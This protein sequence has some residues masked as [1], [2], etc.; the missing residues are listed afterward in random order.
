MK[1][2]L[3]LLWI[4][5]TILPAFSDTLEFKIE[6]GWLQMSDGV[7]LSV[8]YFKPA[9]EGEKYPVLL[10]LLPYRKDD[11]FYLRDYPLGAYFASHGYVVARVDVRGTGSSEGV[12]PTREYSDREIDDAV[13]LVEQLSK[14]PWSNG[15][16]GMY[17][18]S[19]SGFNAIH[20]AMRKPPALKAILAVDASDDLFHDD[21]HFLDGIYHMDRYEL[22]IDNDNGLPDSLEYRLDEEYFRNRFDRE[23][24]LFTYLRNQRDGEFWRKASVRFQEPLEVPTYLIGGLLDFYRDS[25]PRMLE[26]TKA[27]VIAEVGPWNHA[28]PDNGEPGPN[29]EWRRRALRWWDH[30]LKERDT[31]IL[32]EPAF[33]V[34]VR[35]SHLPDSQLKTTPGEWKYQTWPDLKAEKRRFFPRKDGSLGE[36]PEASHMEL[37]YRPGAGTAAGQWWG[38]PMPDMAA[39]D[40]QSLVFDSVPLTE[41]VEIVGFPHVNWRASVDAPLAHWVARL[42][43]VAPD[44]QV[45]LVTGAGL[46]GSQRHSLLEPRSLAP[47]ERHDYSFDLHF[48]T[49]RF[50]PGH[51]I[52][53][54]LSNAQ[55][56]MLWPTPHRMTCVTHLGENTSLT[57][58]V[59][60]LGERPE[61]TTL[62]PV[63]PR[64]ARPDAEDL[65]AEGWP[66]RL[67]TWYD[68]EQSM[69]YWT[70]EGQSRFRIGERQYTTDLST[71]YKVPDQ[72]PELAGFEGK[73]VHHIVL[74][75]DRVLDYST[76]MEVRS[77]A[78]FFYVRT[79]RE[80]AENGKQVRSKQWKESILRDFQ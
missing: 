37:P 73:G 53:L 38:E 9:I 74:E 47:G 41:T 50:P 29:Y 22:E 14:K 5:G 72:H 1:R 64:I 27:P 45:T 4:L 34:F 46:N 58:P 65:P 32:E 25:V 62:P 12:L 66:K 63:E 8:T 77:D 13:E 15:R 10:E 75:N 20:T 59:S 11:M 17:G 16:V 23:P 70:W 18:I 44:G 79:R 35:D 61:V 48:T 31:G 40:A 36:I 80:L 67:E 42:E 33:T 2:S 43:D 51:R 19:W 57:L 26:T 54:A 68:A 6:R 78:K 39:D 52:R 24:W 21:V 28:W 76:W 69:T 7:K 49:W 55:F 71:T 56:P 30:W 3:I 60:A